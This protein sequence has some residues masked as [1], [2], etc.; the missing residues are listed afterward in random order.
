MKRVATALSVLT[1]AAGVPALVPTAVLAEPAQHAT[2]EESWDA[3]ELVP[4]DE[5]PCGHWAMSFRETRE[6]A[7][8]ILMAPGG[9]TEGEMHVN[10][11]IDGTVSLA[12]VDPRLPSYQ[13]SYREKANV[14]LTGVDEETGDDVLRVGQYR[15]RLPLDGSD[16]SRLVM[17]ISG[18]VTMT[19]DGGLAVARGE[20]TCSAR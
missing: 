17:T 20:E 6:G 10:G 13:G 14:V 19:P 1:A 11:A 5:N 15:L 12:P 3:T 9:Q 16:G 8:R 2:Y 4:A 7:Y 18:K